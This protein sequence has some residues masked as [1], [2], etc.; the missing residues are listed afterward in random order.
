MKFETGMDHNTTAL[1]DDNE[2]A[3]CAPD[4]ALP[5]GFKHA[6]YALGGKWKLEILFSPTN[7][8]MR[9]GALRRAVGAA[10]PKRVS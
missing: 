6:I 1:C 3:G 10:L 8:A 2:C 4:P 5:S 7:G 9:P